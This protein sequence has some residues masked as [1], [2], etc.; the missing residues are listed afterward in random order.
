VYYRWQLLRMAEPSFSLG[1]SSGANDAF[2]CKL[3]GSTQ[4]HDMIRN[5]LLVAAALTLA[6][7][8]TF[9][10][11]CRDAKGKFTKCPTPPSKPVKC[12]T[13]NGRFAK[14]STTGAKPI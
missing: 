9:A 3:A 6:A 7:T 13:A 12:K 2:S 4:E 8:P 14:C 5:L 10:A 1:D 11:P